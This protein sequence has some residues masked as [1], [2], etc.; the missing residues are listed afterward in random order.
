[1]VADQARLTRDL[2]FFI[3]PYE[4]DALSAGF[5][6]DTDRGAKENFEKPMVLP[7]PA[8]G[9]TLNVIFW[10]AATPKLS[11]SSGR[12][13][14]V[15]SGVETSINLPPERPTPTVRIPPTVALNTSAEF[16]DTTVSSTLPSF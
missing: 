16:S 15:S 11:G 13:V 7:S 6:S 10:P 12:S 5:E 4:I 2:S 1:M 14:I 9:E 3:S 8:F